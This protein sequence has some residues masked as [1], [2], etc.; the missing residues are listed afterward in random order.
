MK[1]YLQACL[2][3]LAIVAG[4]QGSASA[5]CFSWTGGF[6]VWGHCSTSGDCG[7]CGPGGCGPCGPGGCGG[8]PPQAGPWY[9]YWPYES[10]FQTPSPV[11]YPYW[12]GPQTWPGAAIAPPPA[13]AAYP[14]PVPPSPARAPVAQ[15]D[16]VRPASYRP[17]A[18]SYWYER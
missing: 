18:P 7:P 8:C 11:G 5:F 16:G 4:S 3:S 12:P 15:P 10:H 17:Q 13:P 6:T 14:A 1:T 2:L 9:L